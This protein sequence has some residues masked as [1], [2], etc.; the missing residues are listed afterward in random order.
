MDR[1]TRKSQSSEM[2]WFIDHENNDL[3]LEPC[4][5][6]YSQNGKAI[7]KLAYYEDLEEQGKLA[8]L[9][10]KIGDT[11]YQP[12]YKFTKCSAYDYEPR[13]AHDSECECCEAEC[14]SVCNPYIHVGKV[15]EM[16]INELSKGEVT[17]RVRFTEKF[18]SSYYT[19]GQ[20]VFLSK[21]EAEAVLRGK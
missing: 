4:E 20:S 7:R 14:D 18:D 9:P 17:V 5:M 1:L 19:I 15:V 10:C 8:V 2:V 12:S 6:S 3:N 16:R 13:Y 21:E 11:V